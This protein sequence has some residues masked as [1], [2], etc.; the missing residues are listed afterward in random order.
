MNHDPICITPH[1]KS[2]GPLPV[3]L[4]TGFLGGGKTTLL[5][6]WAAERADL[7]MVFLV[8]ELAGNDVDADR[9][10]GSGAST[11]S[12]V[13]GSIFCECKAADFL[14]ML[15]EDVMLALEK[16]PLDALVIETSGI[17]DP[18]AIGTLIDKAGFGDRLR[19]ASILTLVSP[20][21]FLKLYGRLPVVTAQIEA[22]DTVVINKVD[23]ADAET[24]S[25]CEETLRALNPEAR[26]LRA[27]YGKGVGLEIGTRATPLPQ[28]PLSRCDAVAFDS[29]SFAPRAFLDWTELESRLDDLP[30]SLHRA[31]G[32]VSAGGALYS[33]DLTPDQRRVEPSTEADA[34]PGLVVIAD[35]DNPEALDQAEGALRGKR[36]LIACDVFKE[37]WKAMENKPEDLAPV[38]LPM[39]LH[40][41]PA[42]LREKVQAEIDALEADPLTGEI[43]ML[44]GLCGGGVQG[45]HTSRC[46]LVMPRAHDCIA[47][48]I[49]SNQAHAKIQKDHPGTYFYAPGWIRER[50]VPGPDREK[51]IR[52]E[53]AG[54]FDEDMIEELVEADLEAFEHYDKALYIRT[55]AAN[56][57]E[58]YCRRCADHLNWDLEAVESDP[59]WLRSFFQ[60]PWPEESFLTV[61]PGRRVEPSADERVLRLAEGP[62]A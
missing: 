15:R 3:L 18:T 55:P 13:G 27:E 12:V 34:C 54:R 46:P 5:K 10:R 35:M 33:L 20:S 50:R 21:K 23:L 6:R 48:L 40:D 41:R 4:I 56:G 42:E 59:A 57:E 37:E 61:P 7:R 29:R 36:G 51:W 28:N 2:A 31:K 11:H 62:A 60:G 53:Y 19:V 30:D 47:M 25:Q 17:A 22:A 52:E 8:N 44:Y 26:L 43:L 45:I 24:L 16:D 32:V 39:G 49:G 1:G 9:L 58:A 38:W 14:R